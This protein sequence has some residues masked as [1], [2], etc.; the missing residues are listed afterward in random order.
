MLDQLRLEHAA[1]ECE[2]C[3]ITG[4]SSRVP[5]LRAAIVPTEPAGIHRL[6]AT[7]SAKEPD[8]AGWSQHSR[9]IKHLFSW[10]LGS[11]SSSWGWVH[12]L[13][14]FWKPCPEF[15]AWCLQKS[16]DSD[17][18]DPCMNRR[19]YS[20]LPPT[21]IWLKVRCSFEEFELRENRF[22]FIYLNK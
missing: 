18:T 12:F 6:T 9:G 21:H 3:C 16:M 4:L 1:A 14:L 15:Y 2:A 13:N 10:C 17:A 19:N 5:E 11:T 22:Q 20:S 7:H 8:V